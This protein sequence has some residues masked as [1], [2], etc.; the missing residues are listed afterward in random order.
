MRVEETGS[1]NAQLAQTS[2]LE[3][4]KK[5]FSESGLGMIHDVVTEQARSWMAPLLDPVCAIEASV[6]AS[7]L[8]APLVEDAVQVHHQSNRTSYLA[9]EVVR[10]G[11]P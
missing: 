7:P 4:L 9:V 8:E 6:M 3:A 10:E 11:P 1:A 5:V 2:L